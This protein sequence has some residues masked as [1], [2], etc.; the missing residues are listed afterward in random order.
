MDR[1]AWGEILY[2]LSMKLPLSN[3]SID[4]QI[5]TAVAVSGGVDSMCL[6]SVLSEHARAQGQTLYAFHVH[7]GLQTQADEWSCVVRD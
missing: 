6:L 3:F 5:P 4:L 1:W 2:N 7:H